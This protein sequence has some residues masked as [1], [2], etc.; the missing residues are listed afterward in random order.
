MRP[1]RPM[2]ILAWLLSGVLAATS[3]GPASAEEKPDLSPQALRDASTHVVVGEVRAV[4]SRRTT[5]GDWR[6]TRHVAEVKVQKVEKGAGIDVGGLIYV[7]YWI[8]TWASPRPVPPET[9]GYRDLPIEGQVL[10]IYLAKNANDGFTE[11]NKDGGFNAIGANGFEVPLPPA[12]T[13]P[14]LS[15]WLPARD[16]LKIGVRIH[17]GEGDQKKPYAVVIRFVGQNSRVIIRYTGGEMDGV[18]DSVELSAPWWTRMFV[19]RDDPALK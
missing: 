6:Y 12:P 14:A 7:R 10:R 4:Y 5:E 3:S 17:E 11:D 13:G 16:N 9:G 1:I 2:A 19:R 18:E 15:G 8:R